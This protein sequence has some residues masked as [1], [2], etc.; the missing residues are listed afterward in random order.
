MIAKF[1]SS[2][3]GIQYREISNKYLYDD[4]Y[5]PVF[6]EQDY[7]TPQPL[8]TY[9]N[10]MSIRTFRYKETSYDELHKRRMPVYKEYIKR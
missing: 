9:T 5:I 2:C 1:I 4:Y 7:C 8:T 10:D 3:G 6:I